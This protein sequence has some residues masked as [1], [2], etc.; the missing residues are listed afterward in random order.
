M[1]TPQPSLHYFLDDDDHDVL[2]HQHQVAGYRS[3]PHK[4][5]QLRTVHDSHG[6]H[7]NGGGRYGFSGPGTKNYD[8]DIS[9][10]SNE[11]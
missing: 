3:L 5:Q 1:E 4:S 2:L 11:I 10:F 7:G 8:L 9:I 6:G